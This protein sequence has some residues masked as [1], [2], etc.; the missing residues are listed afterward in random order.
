MSLVYLQHS[1]DH[2]FSTI[3]FML[4]LSTA[5]T[6]TIQQLRM[7]TSG[8]SAKRSK[9]MNRKGSF[10]TPLH[11]PFC[12]LPFTCALLLLSNVSVKGTENMDLYCSMRCVLSQHWPLIGCVLSRTKEHES[13]FLW[14]CSMCPNSFRI[15]CGSLIY[16]LK[17]LQCDGNP[18]CHSCHWHFKPQ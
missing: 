2:E 17:P 1:L 5:P 18:S 14:L 13:A 10:S 6:R 8:H 7:M 3:G 16:F 12:I 11:L 4:H 15:M 9:E